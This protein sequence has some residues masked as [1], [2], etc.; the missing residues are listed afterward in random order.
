MRK[1]TKAKRLS[2]QQSETLDSL[3]ESI[4]VSKEKGEWN[5]VG[6]A[7]VCD[8][9]KIEE[10]GQKNEITEISEEHQIP[11]YPAAILYHSKKV[12]DS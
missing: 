2:K 10:L 7:C 1:K 6:L 3:V 12:E 4:V 11:T 9:N 8:F 5:D